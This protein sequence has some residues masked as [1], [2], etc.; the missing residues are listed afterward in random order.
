MISL[1]S[2]VPDAHVD[3]LDS[4]LSLKSLGCRIRLS[5]ESL[6]CTA[7]STDKAK[8]K[9]E[10]QVRAP[11][12]EPE[13]LGSKLSL[14]SQRCKAELSLESLGSDSELI[15]WGAR[16]SLWGKIIVYGVCTSEGQD[17]IESWV[18][19]ARKMKESQI[20]RVQVETLVGHE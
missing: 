20:S 16:L 13:S 10:A 6:K 15:L 8:V 14:E 9:L 3:S 4:E 19:G 1:K 12:W 11:E 5:F 2:W 18:S 17:Q 7:D